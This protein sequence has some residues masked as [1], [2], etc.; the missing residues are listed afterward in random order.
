MNPRPVNLPLEVWE[1]I[2]D[3]VD[4]PYEDELY[5]VNRNLMELVLARKYRSVIFNNECRDLQKYVTYLRYVWCDHW[6]PIV[7]PHTHSTSANPIL[8]P[9]SGRFA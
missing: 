4:D 2:L 5:S 3:C 9:T 1:H 7:V 8:L 6:Q